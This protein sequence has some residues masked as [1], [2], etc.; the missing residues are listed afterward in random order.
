MNPYQYEC[1]CAVCGGPG[2]AH[3]KDAARDWLG[4]EFTHQDPLTCK[5]YI[6]ARERKLRE[7]IEELQKLVP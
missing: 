3:V 4:V 2:L 7:K 6:K 1:H 5:Q